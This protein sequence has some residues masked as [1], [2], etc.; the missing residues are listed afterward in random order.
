MPYRLS[1]FV[2]LHGF[3]LTVLLAPIAL[4]GSVAGSTAHSQDR[5]F[6]GLQKK[7][8]RDGFDPK[9]IKQAYLNPK[10]RLEVKTVSLYFRHREGKL[11][12]DQFTTPKSIKK[13]RRY[14]DK[15]RVALN[16]VEKRY[17]VDKHAITA[18]L[19]VETRLGRVVGTRS[20]LNTLSTLSALSEPGV[21]NW[22]WK[23]MP[24]RTGLKRE[25][26]E[27]WAAR[28]SKWAYREL[29]SYLT[30]TDRENLDPSAVYGSYAGALGIAQFMPSSI[31]AYARDGNGD[32]RVN[33]FDH[34]DAAASI[35]SYLKNFGWHPGIDKK[36]A[37]KVIFRYNRSSYYVNTVLKI[38]RLLKG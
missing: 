2:L 35:A 23:K 4:P 3:F 17:G 29:K 28:K 8:V 26:Y 12:Y 37:Y 21:R 33:L 20:I 1:R 31:M 14:I 10:V 27:K 5:L 11:N 34:A 16:R 36:K 32:G 9:S 24:K 6:D 38:R 19:L 25:K 18:I 13:A 22:L 7:L 30:Y 15:H